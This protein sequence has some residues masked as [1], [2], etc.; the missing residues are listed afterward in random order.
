MNWENHTALATV[1][2]ELIGIRNVTLNGVLKLPSIIYLQTSDSNNDEVSLTLAHDYGDGIYSYTGVLDNRN[3]YL[4]SMGEGYPYDVYAVELR[5]QQLDFCFGNE[6]YDASML[7]NY[8]V[9]MGAVPSEFTGQDTAELKNT[10]QIENKPS[11]AVLD[12]LFARGDITASFIII[13]PLIWL[14]T[15]IALAPAF[16]KG[17]NTKITVY[18][19]ILV[20][21]P[22]FVFAIQTFIPQRST[23]SIAEFLGVTLMLLSASLLLSVLPNFKKQIALAMDAASFIVIATAVAFTFPIVYS[24]LIGW[25]LPVQLTLVGFEALLFGGLIARVMIYNYES[26]RWY[27]QCLDY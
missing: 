4:Y 2:F 20:F 26:N 7:T 18:S 12:V 13:T 16:T 11:N 23:P 15:I 3:W 9:N 25:W 19:S 27:K 5:V 21:A 8:S 24:R 14:L 10:W 22:M 17:R 1:N 6:R